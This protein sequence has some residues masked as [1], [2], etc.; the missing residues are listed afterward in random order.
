ME[1]MN[2]GSQLNGLYD[3]HSDSSH[4]LQYEKYDT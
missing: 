2:N 1:I 3:K 4:S